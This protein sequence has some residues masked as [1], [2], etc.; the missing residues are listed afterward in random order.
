MTPRRSRPGSRAPRPPV[1][2]PD[3]V[4]HLNSDGRWTRP[5]GR[6]PLAVLQGTRPHPGDGPERFAACRGNDAQAPHRRVPRLAD[7][8]DLRLAGQPRGGSYS[9]PRRGRAA[10]GGARHDRRTT[11]APTLCRRRRDRT[12]WSGVHRRRGDRRRTGG[13]PSHGSGLGPEWPGRGGGDPFPVNR[14]GGCPAGRPGPGG[15]NDLGR[16]ARVVRRRCSGAERRRSVRR[17]AHFG[18]GPGG[19]PDDV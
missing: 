9:P 4:V 19:W 16:P 3:Q 6:P 2:L 5:P 10:R 11:S 7:L 17:P 14:P 15:A 18:R 8:G 1:H 13:Q 12:R